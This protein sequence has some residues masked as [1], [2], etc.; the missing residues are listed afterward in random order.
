VMQL[1]GRG[2]KGRQQQCS[3]SGRGKSSIQCQVMTSA[4]TWG[5]L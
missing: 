2:T 5:M 4:K 3:K 1:A